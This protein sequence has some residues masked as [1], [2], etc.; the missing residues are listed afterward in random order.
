MAGYML[1]MAPRRLPAALPE[2]A[3]ADN[4]LGKAEKLGLIDYSDTP[5]I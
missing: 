5:A 2:L 3:L 4:V 1:I